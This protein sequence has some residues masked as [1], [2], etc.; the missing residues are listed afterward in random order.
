MFKPNLR[1]KYSLLLFCACIIASVVLVGLPVGKV[2]DDDLS[3]IL[4]ENDRVVTLGVGSIWAGV[5]NLNL[6][7]REGMPF[8]L[9]VKW[10]MPCREHN[11]CQ[12]KD[13]IDPDWLES[14]SANA[15][16]PYAVIIQ[17]KINKNGRVAFHPSLKLSNFLVFPSSS[18]TS[19]ILL[20]KQLREHTFHQINAMLRRGKKAS[21][22][23]REQLFSFVPEERVIRD[24]SM[25]QLCY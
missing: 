19:E 3:T 24:K 20:S 6:L 16:S 12:P 21:F 11:A 10:R 15:R 4:R 8:A 7:C 14:K 17:S 22:A 1:M 13:A 5:P 25:K 9:V 23:F 18:G 2:S